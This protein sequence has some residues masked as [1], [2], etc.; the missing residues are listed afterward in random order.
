[1]ASN[2]TQPNQANYYNGTFS[3]TQ[4]QLLASQNN[5]NYLTNVGAFKNSASYYGTFDQGGNVYE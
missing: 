3:V 4:Q 5:Q 1:V 2:G